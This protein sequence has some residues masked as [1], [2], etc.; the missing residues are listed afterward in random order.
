VSV[1]TT[2]TV[3]DL[4]RDV[5]SLRAHAQAWARL[6]FAGKIRHLRTMRARTVEVAAQWA[7]LAARAKGIAGTPLAG[8]E[9]LSGP[10]ALLGALDRL[11][12]TLGEIARDG[13][14]TIPERAIR[15][16]PDGQVVVDVFPL[17][18][19]DVLLLNGVRAEIWMEPGVTRQTVRERTA[20]ALR[21][22]DPQPKVTLVLGAGNI[23]SIPPLDVLAALYAHNSVALL[24]LNPVNAYLEPVL[25]R[26]FSALIDEGFVR[27]TGG[28]A[29]V[30]RYLTAHP[31][32][33]AIHLTGG[34]RTHQAVVTVARD[35]TI[36]SELGNVTPVI[37]VPGPW[38]DADLKFQAAH[39]A[40]MK[41][42][43]AGANCIAAQLLVT[44]RSWE[45]R[46]AFLGRVR[47][48]LRTAP[49]R[50]AYYPGAPD[51][52]RD[53]AASR[54]GAEALG[55]G[56]DGVPRVF[57]P[58][59]D[60]VNA[61]D[62][63]FHDEAFAPV[64]TET[65]LP[66]AD[67]AAFLRN[68]VAFVNEVPHG[69][70]GVSVLIHP[71][72]IAELGPA[73]DDAVAGLRYGCVA[74]NSWPGVGFLLASASW[75]AY[76]GNTLDDVG[77]GIGIVHNAFLFDRPQKT[78]LRQPFAPFPRSLGGERTLLPT[79]P[80]FVTHRRG[81]A[82]GRKLFAYTAKPSLRGLMATALAAMRA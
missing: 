28:G 80:W 38:S 9:W 56:P 52:V 14:P 27:V 16:R 2:M 72:T 62:A 63:F 61:A 66:G 43:N 15:T 50:P 17:E 47:D 58:G 34:E 20:A 12:K 33:D 76:P 25:T 53:A 51:R 79:P 40:T 48:A 37:V 36:T 18:T 59:L 7:E 32:V 6:G 3:G 10:Y 1:S 13:V 35:K 49:P 24:K 44:P 71:R 68:A 81:D 45:R 54:A 21:E 46:D 78:V 74:I 22:S 11:A 70:L 8:E 41:L 19:A 64:L 55:T 5:E 65:A 4:D 29:D 31:G 67:A 60:A 73:F 30:G 82:V 69:T 42:H 75:G 57:V 77:S 39:V 23:A 26:V